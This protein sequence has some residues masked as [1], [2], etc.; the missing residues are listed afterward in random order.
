MSPPLA[1]LFHISSQ[2]C[3]GPQLDEQGEAGEAG[4]KAGARTQ[5]A[6]RLTGV[7]NGTHTGRVPLRGR[8]LWARAC[9][10]GSGHSEVRTEGH[11]KRTKHGGE[12][13]EG[14]L[15]ECEL[16][17]LMQWKWRKSWKQDHRKPRNADKPL[18][19]AEAQKSL[20][21][22]NWLGVPFP[23][24][25]NTTTPWVIRQQS[26]EINVLQRSLWPQTGQIKTQK[27]LKDRQTARPRKD[28]ESNRPKDPSTTHG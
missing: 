25:W 13:L 15:R 6:P 5:G 1:S 24:T 8:A 4:T 10:A 19:L 14:I 17:G 18:V 7:R 23:Q 27:Q 11:L 12:N 3:F 2:L 16:L 26:G 22:D 9:L 28:T 20:S 21:R